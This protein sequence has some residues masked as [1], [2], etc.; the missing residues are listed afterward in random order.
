MTG[1]AVARTLAGM[2]TGASVVGRPTAADGGP[3]RTRSS[4]APF[5]G[6]PRCTTQATFAPTRRS[7]G[8]G[9]GTSTGTGTICPTS[10]G[11]RA[12]PTGT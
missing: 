6:P 4:A 10:G 2:S 12:R 3:H 1:R 9:A 11:T 5:S 7:P 8:T